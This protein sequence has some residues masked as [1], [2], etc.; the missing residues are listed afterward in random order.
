MV[1]RYIISEFRTNQL[2]DIAYKYENVCE[3]VRLILRDIEEE[4]FEKKIGIYGN[5]QHPQTEPTVEA[6]RLLHS[7]VN[8]KHLL[9]KFERKIDL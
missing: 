2:L 3:K 1:H 6:L 5:V 4:Q 9:E 8:D 7:Q